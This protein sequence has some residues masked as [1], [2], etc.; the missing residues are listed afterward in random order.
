[1]SDIEG[2]YIARRIKTIYN[3]NTQTI[4]EFIVDISYKIK[5]ITEIQYLV[6]QVN[7]SNGDIVELLFFKNNNGFLSTSDNGIDNIFFSENN[8]LIHNWS[9]PINSDGDLTNAS[10]VLEKLLK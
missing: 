9:I 6:T 2:S 4:S 1:M 3:T 10:A 5:K 7:L 8:E